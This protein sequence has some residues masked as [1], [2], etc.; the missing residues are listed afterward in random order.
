MG[1]NNFPHDGERGCTHGRCTGYGCNCDEKNYGYR[2]GGHHGGNGA[3]IA[4]LILVVVAS[5]VGVWNEVI[6]TL[7]AIIGGFFIFMSR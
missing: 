6:G 1:G 7:I 5:A 2:G 3:T 4:F